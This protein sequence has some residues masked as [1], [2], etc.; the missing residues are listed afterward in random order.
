MAER[1]ALR[2]YAVGGSVRDLLLGY[3]SVDLDLV[4]EGDAIGFAEALS[5]QLGTRV[6]SYPK[7]QTATI[8]DTDLRLDF[9]AARCETY[10]APGALPV[11]RPANL[12]SDLARRDFTINAMALG[13]TGSHQGRLSDPYGG[14]RDLKSG[15]VRVLHSNS[16]RDD[17]TR[18]FRAVRYAARLRF[19]LEQNTRRLLRRHVEAIRLV[20]AARRRHEL[21]RIA[22]ERHPVRAIRL[23]R[24]IGLLQTSSQAMAISDRQLRAIA[25][26]SATGVAARQREV[27]ITILVGGQSADC[28]EGAIAALALTSRQVTLARALQELMDSEDKLDVFDTPP[29]RVVETLARQPLAAIQ[30]FALLTDRPSV[31]NRLRSYLDVW[32]FSRTR[33]NGLD[34]QALGVAPGP[35]LGFA[36]RELRAARLDGKV[37]TR[38]DE[39]RFIQAI[40]RKEFAS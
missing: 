26:A 9:T 24:T 40:A 30:A 33:L 34:L 36:L 20:S 1:A 7:F 31:R 32:R 19:R 39:V 15:L 10:P 3:S 5:S 4:L 37:S 14:R 25:A 29:S 27:I 18:M 13:L 21:E 12:A 38:E 2:L 35:K 11:V 6:V 23:A 16:F 17:P 8:T 28:L 22:D